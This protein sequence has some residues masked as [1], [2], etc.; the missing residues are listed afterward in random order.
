VISGTKSGFRPPPRASAIGLWLVLASLGML[1]LSSMLLYA[2][3]RLHVFGKA[4]DLP[5]EMPALA[6]ASTAVLLAASFTIHRA[7][8]SISNERLAACLKFLRITSALAV[9]FLVIQTPCM[10]QVLQKHRV[11]EEKIMATRQTGQ[12]SPVTLYGLVFVLI[13]LHA[14]HV[15]GG[16]VAL[17]VV[18]LRASRRVYDHEN[19]MGIQFVARYWHFLDIVWLT[20]FGMFLA[21][22]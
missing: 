9:L 15:L 18:T 5:I 8:V 16:I 13:L 17:A 14:L 1:F 6:W 2:L 21:L 4:S 19:Y 3:M 12:I 7:A 20:M 11:I 10:W 22:G